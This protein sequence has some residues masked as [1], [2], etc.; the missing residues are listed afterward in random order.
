MDPT[1]CANKL[2]DFLDKNPFHG[3]DLDYEDTAGFQSGKAID[4]LVT[5]TKVVKTRFPSISITHAPQAPYFNAD[6][7]HGGYI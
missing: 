7:Y 2:G 5:F 3:V 4:W 6:M 1:Q